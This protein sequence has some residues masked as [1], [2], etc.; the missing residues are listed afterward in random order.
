MSESRGKK[1]EIDYIFA[2]Y[3]L[4]IRYSGLPRELGPV[5]WAVF[6]RL[7]ELRE[8]FESQKFFYA[9]ERL[10]ETSGIKNKRNMVSIL[11]RLAT[12]KLIKYLTTAGRGKAT[13]FE[14]LEPLNTPL[15]EEDVYKVYPR[16]SSKSYIKKLRDAAEEQKKMIHDHLLEKETEKVIH[17]PLLE[18][19]KVIH[20][21]LLKTEK[22]IHD[23]L[24]EEEKVIRDHPIKKIYIKRQQQQKDL[25]ISGTPDDPQDVPKPAE[26]YSDNA[27][28]APNTQNLKEYGISGE[29]AERYTRIYAP[30]YIEDKIE[31]IEYKRFKGEQIRNPGGMLKKAIEEDWQRPEGFSTRAQREEA[32]RAA[33]EAEKAEKLK[34][35]ERLE[36]IKREEE[37]AAA[38]E[39]WRKAAAPEILARIR[40]RAIQE[41]K[42]RFPDTDESLLRVP[43][44]LEENKIIAKEFLSPDS[45]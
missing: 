41:V 12:C 32:A 34:E 33:K 14:I 28:V 37:T 3:P 44:R 38:A 8:R 40:E 16:L 45:S 15:T 10:A 11:E 27:V 22:A 4:W 24:L 13:A 1:G 26:P 42:T 35:K 23:P 18:E 39:E 30:H 25:F 21:P 31:I 29:L 20:D 36:N 5:A 6:Q 17:D 7:L 9:L 43:I 19:E 2:R